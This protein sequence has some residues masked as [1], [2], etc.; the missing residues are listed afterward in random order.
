MHHIL[1]LKID[2]TFGTDG[3]QKNNTLCISWWVIERGRGSG[4]A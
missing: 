3:I 1:S 2:V 4:L